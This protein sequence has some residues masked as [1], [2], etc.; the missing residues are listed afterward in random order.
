MHDNSALSDAWF[1][2]MQQLAVS[3]DHAQQGWQ[4][5]QQHYTEPNRAYHNFSHIAAMLRHLAQ[6]PLT[7]HDEAVLKLAIWFHDLIYDPKAKDNE[8]RSAALAVQWMQQAGFGTERCDAV[9]ACILATASHQLSLAAHV[10]DAALFLDLDLSVLGLPPARYR[11]YA[12]AIRKE[13]A[14][15][16][17]IPYRLGRAG[18]LQKFLARSELYFTPYFRQ[19]LERRPDT[20]CS[21]NA[22]NTFLFLTNHED[23]RSF[24]RD[25]RT[26]T[27]HADRRTVLRAYAGGIWCRCHQNRIA[28]RR[29]S[30]APV[31]CAER[32]HF[33]VVERAGAQ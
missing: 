21:A 3:P 13:Y 8:V 33:A 15:V 18:V 28:R 7:V 4:Q 12:A 17:A 6:S 2:L 1:A 5:L 32:W 22:V 30:F 11:L 9:N 14:W 10:P 27:R 24:V 26:G 25:P 20:I 29:R 16:A 31:A 19:R 23:N